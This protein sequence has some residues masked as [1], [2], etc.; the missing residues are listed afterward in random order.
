LIPDFKAPSSFAL[1]AVRSVSYPS[2]YRGAVKKEIIIA[3]NCYGVH[4]GKKGER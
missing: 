1:L 3:V 4:L 2:R